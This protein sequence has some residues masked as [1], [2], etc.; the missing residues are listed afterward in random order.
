MR[1]ATTYWAIATC[2]LV[3]IGCTVCQ[4]AKRTICDEPA[5]YSWKH[6]RRRSIEAYRQLADEVWI[7]TTGACPELSGAADYASG[8]HDGFVDYVYAGGSGEPPPVPPRHFWNAMLRTPDGKARADQ[9]FT[10]YR[11][12]ARVARDGGYREFGTVDSSLVAMHSAMQDPLP[13]HPQLYSPATDSQRTGEE[14]LPAPFSA[15]PLSAPAAPPEPLRANHDTFDDNGPASPAQPMNEAD[16]FQDDPIEE[17]TAPANEP[18]SSDTPTMNIEQS[19]DMTADKSVAPA[20]ANVE[21]NAAIDV[22][23]I[24][25]KQPKAEEVLQA[26]QQSAEPS[27]HSTV[28]F[29]TGETS[30]AEP[31]ANRSNVNSRDP[32]TLTLSHL[33]AQ[34]GCEPTTVGDPANSQC[35]WVS[36]KRSTIRIQQDG[37]SVPSAPASGFIPFGVT[38]DR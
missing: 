34:A 15:P 22:I 26:V 38:F 17:N 13:V 24:S 27:A 29:M 28:R 19:N 7:E 25:A 4:N 18:Q 36:T 9:W 23:L 1:C 32:P 12:G 6:D 31:S 35:E 11:H 5:A 20:I 2:C 33:R 37:E 14:D 16:A 3:S 21:E 8:F 30:V 10:G